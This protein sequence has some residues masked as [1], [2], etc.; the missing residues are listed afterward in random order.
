MNFVREGGA[1]FF[2][3]RQSQAG[4]MHTAVCLACNVLLCFTY[5]TSPGSPSQL[6]PSVGKLK[7]L[8]QWKV[9]LHVP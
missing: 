4:E 6:A 8:E 9:N 1:Y 3:L 7:L 5:A 2:T